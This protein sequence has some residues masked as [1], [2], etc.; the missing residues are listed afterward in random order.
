MRD[1]EAIDAE[2]RLL[3]AIRRV[4]GKAE[5]RASSTARIDEL[6]DEGIDDRD[7]ER[8]N[9]RRGSRKP[10]TSG[11]LSAADHGLLVSSGLQRGMRGTVCERIQSSSTGNP[12]YSIASY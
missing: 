5:G 1:L 12:A 7:G 8:A 11:A 9:R 4:V 2:L 10:V 3:V 6:L